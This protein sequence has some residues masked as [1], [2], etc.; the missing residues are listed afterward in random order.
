MRWIRF[1]LL[2]GR[3]VSLWQGLRKMVPTWVV[4]GPSLTGDNTIP[5]PL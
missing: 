2:T 4:T 1:C 3:L 5:G